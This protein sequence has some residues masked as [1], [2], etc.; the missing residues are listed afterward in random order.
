MARVLSLGLRAANTLGILNRTISRERESISG[1]TAGSLLV[2]GLPI[3]CMEGENLPGQM[4][5]ATRESMSMTKSMAKELL[6]GVMAEHIQEDGLMVNRMGG[7]FTFI[8]MVK[9]KKENGGWA[10]EFDGSMSKLP[11]VHFQIHKAKDL[12][13]KTPTLQLLWLL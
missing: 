13:P 2:S 4:E 10:R 3:K 8:K 12:S 7:E 6:S 9:N 11:P 1:Q 5:G